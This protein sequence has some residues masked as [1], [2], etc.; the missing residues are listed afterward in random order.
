MA[1]A[2]HNQAV[3]KTKV[4][5]VTPETITLVLSMEEASALMAVCKRIGGDP[6]ASPRKYFDS[7]LSSLYNVGVKGKAYTLDDKYHSIYFKITE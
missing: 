2:T 5:E 3:T 4:V 6:F 1:Q 7:I